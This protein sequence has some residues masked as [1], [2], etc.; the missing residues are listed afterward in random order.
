M[1]NVA[2]TEDQWRASIYVGDPAVLSNEIAF[3]FD[4]NGAL[5]ADIADQ[6]IAAPVVD[7]RVQAITSGLNAFTHTMTF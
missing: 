3:S 7:G 2:A 6:T 5:T 4:E 1:A